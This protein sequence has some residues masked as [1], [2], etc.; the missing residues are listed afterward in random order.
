MF[1]LNKERSV[2]FNRAEGSKNGLLDGLA[3]WFAFFHAL[4]HEETN[5]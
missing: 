5:L 3:I 1:G 2:P 4:F